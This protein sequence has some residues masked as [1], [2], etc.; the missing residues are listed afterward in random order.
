MQFEHE[1]K[2]EYLEN[3][4][5]SPS[6]KDTIWS[7]IFTGGISRFI[8]Q[9]V[10]HNITS[11]GCEGWACLNTI[12]RNINIKKYIYEEIEDKT[13]MFTNKL[14]K[15]HFYRSAI[16]SDLRT[17]SQ[18]FKLFYLIGASWIHWG[19]YDDFRSLSAH[20]DHDYGTLEW[21]TTE[22]LVATKGRDGKWRDV[23]ES[24]MRLIHM[25]YDYNLID[26]LITYD[27]KKSFL[28]SDST[29]LSEN[30]LNKEISAYILRPCDR[31]FL[32]DEC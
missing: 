13:E 16:I 2:H 4:N 29:S 26:F 30:Y 18:N 21:N 25:K 8:N 23:V 19:K 3:F 31:H 9:M 20:G 22:F 11:N 32:L 1:L 5:R 17:L 7:Y 15:Y 14:G 12:E 24:Q 27:L 28:K 10:I 6:Y